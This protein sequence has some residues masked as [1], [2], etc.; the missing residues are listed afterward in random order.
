MI[1][2]INSKNKPQIV[3][4]SKKNITERKAKAEG[5]VSFEPKIF[6]KIQ[7]MSTKKG[8]LENVAILAGIMGAKETSRII[9]LC[10]NIKLNYIN[11]D[12]KKNNKTN[13]L[14]IIKLVYILV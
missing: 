13:S 14:K 5:F 3:D 4:I 2:H 10:H 9:P 11:I 6:N 1:N 8:S 7:K 12:I